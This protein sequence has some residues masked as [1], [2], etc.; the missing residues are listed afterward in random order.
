MIDLS[1]ALAAFFDKRS[2]L[3]AAKANQKAALEALG[4]SPGNDWSAYPDELRAVTGG[5]GTYQDSKTVTA[6]PAG[7]TITPDEGYS[8][9]LKAIIAAEPNFQPWNLV[10]GIQAWGITGTAKP[11]TTSAATS[12]LPVGKDDADTA[13]K[14]QSGAAPTETDYFVCVDNDGNITYWYLSDDFT[15]TS[16]DPITTE[17]KATGAIRMAYHTNGESAGTWTLDDFTSAESGGWNYLK[18]IRSCTRKKLYC[19]IGGTA[20]EVWPNSAWDAANKWSYNG[21]V[22]PKLPNWDKTKYPYAVIG[23]HSYDNGGGSYFFLANNESF[24]ADEGR[25]TLSYITIRPVMYWS[26]TE[27]NLSEWNSIADVWESLEFVWSNHDLYD[28]GG[29]VLVYKSSDPVPV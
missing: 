18:N 2:R 13:Y 29:T 20:Y 21:T 16:Y 1:A 4:R 12:N 17:F 10:D 19:T 6:D 24:L 23:L 15:I 7:M 22:L 9:M 26:T 5:S 25:G 3:S 8:G 27:E 14:T 11:A 28:S